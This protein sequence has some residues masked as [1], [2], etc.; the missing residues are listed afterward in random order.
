M[1][2]MSVQLQM[3]THTCVPS[4]FDARMPRVNG[5]MQLLGDSALARSMPDQITHATNA[6]P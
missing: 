6:L 1:A 3:D 4:A 5:F 2:E